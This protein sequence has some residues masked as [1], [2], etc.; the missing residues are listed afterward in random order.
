MHVSTGKLQAMTMAAMLILVSGGIAVYAQGQSNA[1]ANSAGGGTPLP[2]AGSDTNSTSTSTVITTV[3]TTTTTTT[4]T[5]SSSTTTAPQTLCQQSA[6]TVGRLVL[7][8]TAVGASAT[9]T[10]AGSLSF[11]DRGCYASIATAGGVFNVNVVLKY[12]EPVT[13]YNVVLVANGTSYALGSM[14]TEKNGAGSIDNQ[15]LLKTGTYTVSIQIFDVSSTPGTS[16]LVLQTGQGTI[17]S[18]PLPT[19]NN[20]DQPHDGFDQGHH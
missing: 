16:A 14:V 4:T 13:Q 17:V 8:I 2:L 3:T 18:S 5:T 1:Q 12:A 9:A 7:P 6:V 11:S 19:T 15:V 20:G 10:S